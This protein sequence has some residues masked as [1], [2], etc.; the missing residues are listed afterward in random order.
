MQI[1]LATQIASSLGALLILIA[2]IGH[3]FHW[4]DSGRP[5]YNILNAIGSGVL[6]Y[7]AMRPFQAGFLMMEV[8]WVI[9]SLYA[10]AKALRKYSP[11]AQA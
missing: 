10:L 1:T 4:M 2:Y 7:I 3:Q 5:L 9:V 6:A 11:Q 8:A